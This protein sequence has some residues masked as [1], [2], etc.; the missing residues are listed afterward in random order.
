VTSPKD[1]LPAPSSQGEVNAF[2]AKVAATSAPRATGARGRLIFA[3]DATASREAAWDRACQ[4]QAQMFEETAALGGLDVQLCYYRGFREFHTSAWQQDARGLLRQMTR[5]RCAAGT[6]QLTR[7]LEHVLKEA[8]AKPVNAFVFVGD[9]MEEELDRLCDLAGRLGLQG[10]PA[11]VFQEGVEPGAARAF[12]EVARLSGG[13]YSSFD[14]SSAS[15][16]RELL[17]AVAVYAAGGRKALADL[18]ARRGGAALALT[19]QLP[20]GH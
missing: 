11:F 3:M 10:V 9:C 15:Q 13:A 1:K 4:L 2:L 14:A 16:L 17:S 18:G 8:S 19:H 6:T 12:R 20:D 5:V 7:V